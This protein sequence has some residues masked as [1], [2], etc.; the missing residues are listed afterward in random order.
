MLVEAATTLTDQAS[1]GCAAET[2]CLSTN[3]AKTV[4]AGLEA[5]ASASF[6]LGS[7]HRINPTV[8]ASL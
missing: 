1:S 2:R 4:H 6:D 8:S 3:F 5:L 7:A